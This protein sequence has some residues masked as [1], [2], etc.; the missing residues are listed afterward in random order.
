MLRAIGLRKRYGTTTALDG[1]DLHI[2]PGEILGLIGHNGAGKSTFVRVVAGLT[3]PDAG[4]VTVGG[5]DVTTRPAAARRLLGLA[6]QE[7]GLYLTATVREN[8]RLFGGLAGLRGRALR[9]AITR[10][11]Q[12]LRLEQ[13][14]DRPVRVLSGGQRRRAQVA[15]VL[16]HRPR[17]L[18]LDEP[19]AGADPGARQALLDA[20]RHLAAAGTAICYTTHYLP[21]L[22][23]LGASIAVAARGRVIARGTRDDLLSG[24]PAQVRITGEDGEQRV[25]H[26]ADP[27][28]ILAELLATGLRVRAVDIRRPSLDDLYRS[29]AGIS[30]ADRP[31]ADPSLE[32]GR[33]AA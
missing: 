2:E 10:T 5:I 31:P 23:D 18:L 11:A 15:T 3:R 16:V 33:A 13:V 6:P 1:F 20:L 28:R 9:A 24:L 19:T 32:A 22:D 4:R 26:G 8:L 30:P 12:A 27:S 7:L 25:L 17:L 14:L 29:L 21:E